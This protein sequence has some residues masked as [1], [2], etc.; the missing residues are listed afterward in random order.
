MSKR[1]VLASATVAIVIVAVG[2]GVPRYIGTQ[3]KPSVSSCVNNLRWIDGMKEQWAL[4]HAQTV[5]AQTGTIFGH[6]CREERIFQFVQVAELT[7][8]DK[9]AR[10]RHAVIPDI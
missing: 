4:E 3:A 7:Q 8:S 5:N 9:E 6:I 1:F 10:F 2:I